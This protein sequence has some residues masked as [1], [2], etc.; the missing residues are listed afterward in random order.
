[1]TKVPGLEEFGLLSLVLDDGEGASEAVGVA[2]RDEVV[3]EGVAVVDKVPE[4]DIGLIPDVA[5]DLRALL[6]LVLDGLLE[7][8]VAGRER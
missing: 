3:D 1:M 2:L 4:D 7:Q 5:D 6:R 8:V